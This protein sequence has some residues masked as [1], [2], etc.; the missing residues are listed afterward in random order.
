MPPFSQRSDMHRGEIPLELSSLNW[1]EQILIKKHRALQVF[2]FFYYSES[3][4]RRW[5]NSH[6]K[7]AAFGRGSRECKAQ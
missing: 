6:R 7:E 3:L 1:L 2:R 5:Y 4:F